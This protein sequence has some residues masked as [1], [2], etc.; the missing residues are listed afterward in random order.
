MK[1]LRRL[2][3]D[4]GIENEVRGSGRRWTRIV[5]LTC[6]GLFVLALL[7]LIVGDYI[8]LRGD[9]IVLRDRIDVG[10]EYNATIRAVFVEEGQE[11]ERGDPI[12]ALRSLDAR[13]TLATLRRDEA[14]LEAELYTAQAEHK[15]LPRLIELAR[16]RYAVAEARLRQMRDMESR[17][18]VSSADLGQAIDAEFNA[19]L[20][21]EQLNASQVKAGA[22]QDGLTDTLRRLRGVIRGFEN[23]YDGGTVKAPVSG[24]IAPD[25]PYPGTVVEPGET[26]LSVLTGRPY[27]LGYIPTG[28]LY[29]IDEGDSVIVFSGADTYRGR[30]ERVSDYARSVPQ[31]LLDTLGRPERRRVVRIVFEGNAPPVF[32]TVTVRHAALAWL[33]L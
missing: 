22:L 25:I 3:Y 19:K 1:R 24:R 15:S 29:S 20:E 32:S 7:R 2:T 10:V 9:G 16:S 4:S 8:V 17:N 31:E 5:Y 12:F 13:R 11:V 30:V 14:E 6:L 33:P 27:V 28:T 21:L 18:L 26:A 23:D